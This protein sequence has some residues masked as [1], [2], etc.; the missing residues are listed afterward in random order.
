[1]SIKERFKICPNCKYEW[2]ARTPNPPKCP[3]CQAKLT[4][5]AQKGE[6]Q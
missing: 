3:Q 4:S 5:C 6:T 2:L 1:M